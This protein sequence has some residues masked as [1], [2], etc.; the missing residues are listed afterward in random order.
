MPTSVADRQEIWVW[1]QF[2]QVHYARLSQKLA[3][4]PGLRSLGAVAYFDPKSTAVLL[5]LRFIGGRHERDLLCEWSS[6]A[7]L[8]ALD[9][10][11]WSKRKRNTFSSAVAPFRCTGYEGTAAGRAFELAVEFVRASSR[12]LAGASH[13]VS[14]GVPRSIEVCDSFKVEI[15]DH[16]LARPRRFPRASYTV[17]TSTSGQPAWGVSGRKQPPPIPKPKDPPTSVTPAESMPRFTGAND[18]SVPY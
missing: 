14:D 10:K 16:V 5:R 13:Q 9:T 15:R 2:L 1:I 8:A 7:G 6:S 17:G 11:D 3:S 4:F 18:S 12:A